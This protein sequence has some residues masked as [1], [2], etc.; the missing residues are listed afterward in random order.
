[1]HPAV[2]LA[3]GGGVS[4][5]ETEHPRTPEQTVFYR[6]GDD[7][8]VAFSCK[9]RGLCPSG[10]ARRMSTMAAQ[11]GERVPPDVPVRQWVLSLPRPVRYH[12]A[13]DAALCTAV[14]AV[15]RPVAEAAPNDPVTGPLPLL[16][17]YAAASIQASGSTPSWPAGRPRR[18]STRAAG[19]R[20]G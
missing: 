9:G 11:L 2:P 13:F 15:F 8:V 4:G 6:C 5:G 19:A 17:G 20:R 7:L 10:G 14:L 12:L 18:R 16:A 1:M 3:D